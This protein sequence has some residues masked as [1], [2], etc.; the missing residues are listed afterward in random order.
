MT[1]K[2][3]SHKGRTQN[4]CA[5]DDEGNSLYNAVW[6]ILM[7]QWCELP[8]SWE[9][10][11]KKYSTKEV[12]FDDKSKIYC[13][14]IV[15]AVLGVLEEEDN[16]SMAMR[17]WICKTYHVGQREFLDAKIYVGNLV[18]S[19]RDE[20]TCCGVPYFVIVERFRSG[21]NLI[22]RTSAFPMCID[23]DTTDEA[24]VPLETASKRMAKPKH[25]T[26]AEIVPES[27][28]K[29]KGFRDESPPGTSAKKLPK[30]K[31]LNR[32]SRNVISLSIR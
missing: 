30:Q 7:A 1:R 16:D 25:P 24:M 29:A 3:W 9:K 19:V 5:P 8:M 14:D 6:N 4:A 2:S 15:E 20:H 31:T 21:I 32:T 23:N 10:D 26:T 12:L 22:F 11:L 18:K 17:E 27:N 13:G 28:A